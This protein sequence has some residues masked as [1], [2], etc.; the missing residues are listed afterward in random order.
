MH[1]IY[2]MPENKTNFGGEIISWD[3]EEYERYE[4]GF[5]WYLVAGLINIA[6]VVYAFY[7][8]NFLFA[9]IVV[10]ASFVIIL[11]DSGEPNE[12]NF[13]IA[14]DGI[15]V[16]GKFYDFNEIKNFSIVYKPN[17]DLKKLYF[18]FKTPIRNRLSIPLYDQDPLIIRENLLKYLVEDL[19]RKDEPT[20]EVFSR[21][22]KI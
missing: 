13:S 10:M 14:Y 4:R 11:H 2:N 9:V 16:G 12:V 17:Q 20:S 22:F 3:I 19:E 6:F 15:A 7:S 18:E 1:F 8:N 21:N 5:G